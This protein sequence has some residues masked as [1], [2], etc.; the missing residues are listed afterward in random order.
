M[1]ASTR[2][3]VKSHARP[4]RRARFPLVAISAEGLPNQPGQS[5]VWVGD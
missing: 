4:N 5:I 3:R 1:A 2:Q